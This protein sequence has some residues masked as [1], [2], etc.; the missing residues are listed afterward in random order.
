M[1]LTNEKLDYLLKKEENPSFNETFEFKGK[2]KET[3]QNN[4][5]MF[6]LTASL[7]FVFAVTVTL[8]ILLRSSLLS[9]PSDIVDNTVNRDTENRETYQIMEPSEKNDFLEGIIAYTLTSISFNGEESNEGH[10]NR[11]V[12]GINEATINRIINGRYVDLTSSKMVSEHAN[13]G[14]LIYDIVE[15]DYICGT[16]ILNE[17]ADQILNNQNERIMIDSISTPDTLSFAVWNDATNSIS[18]RYIYSVKSDAFTEIPV[19]SQ[20]DFEMIEASQDFKYI[21][22]HAVRK[23]D[24]EYDDVFLIN[25]QSGSVK[26]I[27]DGFP[28]FMLSRFTP[29]GQYVLNALKYFDSTNSFDSEYCRFIVTDVNGLNTLECKGKVVMYDSGKLLTRDS[30]SVHH[31]YDLIENKEV[32]ITDKLYY[33][34]RNNNKLL[35]GNAYDN[36]LKVVDESVSAIYISDNGQYVYTYN[37]GNDYILR[38]DL[39]KDNNTKINLD[40]AFVNETK[41]MSKTSIIT[42]TL[43]ANPD[44]SEVVL[45]YNSRKKENKPVDNSGQSF[46]S[47]KN[48]DILTAIAKET[49]NIKNTLSHIKDKYPKRDFGLKAY[50]GD[51]WI[52]LY[53][54]TN[55]LDARF[56]FVEDYRKNTFTIYYEFTGH[57]LVR[58]CSYKPGDDGIKQLDQVKDNT[59]E[60]IMQNNIPI[61]VADIDYEVFYDHGKFSEKKVLDY[62]LSFE[63][64]SKADWFYAFAT[65]VGVEISD[66]YFKT[67]FIDFMVEFGSCDKKAKSIISGDYY[68]YNGINVYNR[69]EL[70]PMRDLKGNYYININGEKLYEVPEKVFLDLVNLSIA[71]S[72]NNRYRAVSLTDIK[73][74]DGFG[75]ITNKVITTKE[76]KEMLETGLKYE[77]FAGYNSEMLYLNATTEDSYNNGNKIALVEVCEEDGTRGF[78]YLFY[79]GDKKEITKAILLDDTLCF[80]CDLIKDGY[81]GLKAKGNCDY[82]QYNLRQIRIW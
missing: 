22:S 24:P 41:E 42:Y 14:F 27:S 66:N 65:G 70:D 55:D 1:K 48:F 62:M 30:D 18:R 38:R 23:T 82:P 75:E 15:D 19:A 8:M 33:W 77:K 72:I 56:A 37:A 73:Y 13:H 5:R 54:E 46:S 2:P 4:T 25:T 29:D 71:S 58:V 81:T 12:A 36:T 68:G 67:K 44:G 3:K 6:I 35:V 17:K 76:L 78:V 20:N 63:Y 50:E 60:F 51:G 49:T 34:D 80:C 7:V 9:L 53:A 59:K 57:S 39:N 43:R 10:F 61:D 32:E 69:F 74:A 28:T 40:T 45:L 26:N 52:T 47:D 64:A 31:L 21:V 11:C 16:C 79:R